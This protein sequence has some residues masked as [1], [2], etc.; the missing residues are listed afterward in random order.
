MKQLLVC[1]VVGLSIVGA[2]AAQT[3]TEKTFTPENADIFLQAERLLIVENDRDG[4]MLNLARLLAA[5]INCFERTYARNFF[6]SI[7]TTSN[8]NDGQPDVPAATSAQS[9]GSAAPVVAAVETPDLSETLSGVSETETTQTGDEASLTELDTPLSSNTASAPI[10]GQDTVIA[11]PS[12]PSSGPRSTKLTSFL[13]GDRTV[14]AVAE[15][16]ILYPLQAAAA[17]IEGEC[18]VLFAVSTDGKPRDWAA[19]CSDP[20][21]VRGAED[22]ISRMRFV[23]KL[24]NG[25]AVERENAVYAINFK[26][27][28]LNLD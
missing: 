1:S 16:L 20:I 23:P 19:T 11:K 21:F 10:S 4:A 27:D 5:D 6:N 9:I 13:E 12:E 22:A 26:L 3:C 25:A 7:D 15:P 24:E 2:S 8:T 14:Q 18:E 28:M 17:K